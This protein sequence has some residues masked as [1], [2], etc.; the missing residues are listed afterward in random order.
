[1]LALG[2]MNENSDTQQ[3]KYEAVT[4]A[5]PAY[6][7]SPFHAHDDR[8]TCIEIQ[9]DPVPKLVVQN[10]Q[11][12]I[13]YFIGDGTFDGGSNNHSMEY[14]RDLA[15]DVDDATWATLLAQT[16]EKEILLAGK[17]SLIGYR[18]EDFVVATGN[19]TLSAPDIERWLP[20]RELEFVGRN[21]DAIY[22]GASNDALTGDG[23]GEVLI[24]GAGNDILDGGAGHDIAVFSGALNDYTI[25]TYSGGFTFVVPKGGQVSGHSGADRLV[26]VEAL[27]FVSD[28]GTQTTTPPAETSFPAL[29]YTAS[30]VDLI[31]AFGTNSAAA[32]NHYINNGFIEGR[33]VTFDGLDYIASYRDLMNAFGANAD[34]G[35]SHYIEHGWFE[36]RAVSFDGL[37]YLA[38]HP[39]LVSALGGPSLSDA[40]TA[41]DRGAVHYINW[42]YAESR[43]KDSFDATQYLNNYSDLQTA[44]GDDLDAATLHYI[45]SGYFEGRTDDSLTPLGNGAMFADSGDPAQLATVGVGVQTNVSQDFGII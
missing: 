15:W 5:A 26:N 19:D 27:W 34:A 29:D 17:R 2:V 9:N 8:I 41:G 1:M 33:T 36:G 32:F 28:D 30:Y 35:S 45:R 23:S 44:F 40:K 20:F 3:V 16:G 4:F 21:I 12:D 37:Q 7:D 14:Y 38:S 39:D 11:G 31:N 42:G 18:T 43:V 6:Y 13:L 22:G 25:N 10:P 24:G